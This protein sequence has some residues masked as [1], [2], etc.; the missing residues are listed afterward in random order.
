MNPKSRPRK[1]FTIIGALLAAGVVLALGREV[2]VMSGT[3]ATFSFVNTKA[4]P[5]GSS[6]STTSSSS[7]K[8]ASMTGTTTNSATTGTP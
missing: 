8:S 4:A 2:V 3:K 6:S 1:A 5:G 7:T